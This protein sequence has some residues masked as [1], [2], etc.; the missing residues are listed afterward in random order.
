M[1]CCGS[2]LDGSSDGS[3]WISNGLFIGF[4]GKPDDESGTTMDIRKFKSNDDGDPE[5]DV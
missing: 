2:S 1:F 3:F 5:D 4:L